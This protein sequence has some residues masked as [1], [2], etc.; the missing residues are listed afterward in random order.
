MIQSFFFLGDWADRSTDELDARC[1]K[2]ID[3]RRSLKDGER[4]CCVGGRKEE[5]GTDC[6]GPC[7]GVKLFLVGYEGVVG[8][9]IEDLD[10][11]MGFWCV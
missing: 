9:K 3:G 4:D 1:S 5:V 6:G 8:M 10:L 2:D 7:A 11:F